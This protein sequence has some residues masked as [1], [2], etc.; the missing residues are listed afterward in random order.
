MQKGGMLDRGRRGGIVME[1]LKALDEGRGYAYLERWRE[2]THI[3]SG[4]DGKI[5]IRV[6]GKR[7]TDFQFQRKYMESD[8]WLPGEG[9]DR[10]C[11]YCKDIDYLNNY[12][13]KSHQTLIL[14]KH[15][16]SHCICGRSK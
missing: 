12:S 11:S 5:Y 3:S 7:A 16:A 9:K 1:M 15:L 4:G 10:K 14:Q 13:N 6:Y 2:G 8:E